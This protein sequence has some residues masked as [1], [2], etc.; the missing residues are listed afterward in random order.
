MITLLYAILFYKPT[1]CGYISFQYKHSVEKTIYFIL[2]IAFGVLA[3]APHKDYANSSNL[4]ILFHRQIIMHQEF[5]QERFLIS[6]SSLFTEAL[7]T[8]V[9]DFG[10]YA[11]P[12][13]T[14]A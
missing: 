14:R 5:L 9:N 4:N 11:Q 13:Q 8:I 6:L 2:L 3:M 7:V 1:F 12:Y 10:T